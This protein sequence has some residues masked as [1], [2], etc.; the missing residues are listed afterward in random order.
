[1]QITI[2]KRAYLLSTLTCLLALGTCSEKI[3]DDTIYASFQAYQTKSSLSVGHTTQSDHV[4]AYIWIPNYSFSL[5]VGDV[6]LNGTALYINTAPD[7]NV[8]YSNVALNGDSL[9]ISLSFDGSYQRFDVTG[10]RHF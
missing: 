9:P 1:M 8:W 2:M 5:W 10:D 7:G 3:V 4:D 6:S